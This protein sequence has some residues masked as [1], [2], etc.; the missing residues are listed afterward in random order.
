MMKSGDFKPPKSGVV[1]TN[2]QKEG[3][4]DKDPPKNVN[5]CEK[6]VDFMGVEEFNV[7][8][9]NDDPDEDNPFGFFGLQFGE[10]STH[11]AEP[12]GPSKLLKIGIALADKNSGCGGKKSG[13][14][15][16]TTLEWWKAYLDSCASYHTFLSRRSSRTSK[17]AV[18]R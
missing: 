15:H 3:D 6:F 13:R 2:V 5:D 9:L 1:N 16:R 12:Q 18:A 10:F 17:K 14:G 4:G 7:C 8:V 11:Q